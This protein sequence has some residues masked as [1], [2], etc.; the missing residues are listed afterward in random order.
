MSDLGVI[1]Y[2]S[3]LVMVFDIWVSW[4]SAQGRCNRGEW[5]CVFACYHTAVWHLGAKNPTL[6]SAPHLR[7]KILISFNEWKILILIKEVLKVLLADSH[8]GLEKGSSW[9]SLDGRDSRIWRM[10]CYFGLWWNALV[11]ELPRLVFRTAYVGFFSAGCTLQ[12]SPWRN[13]H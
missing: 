2:K 6:H 10:L 5:Y 9:L 11:S 4:K 8:P 13:N 7:Y 12:C 3:M 1:R